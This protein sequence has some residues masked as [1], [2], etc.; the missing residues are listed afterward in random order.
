MNLSSPYRGKTAILTAI[1]VFLPLLPLAAEVTGTVKLVGK[2]N[3]QDSTFYAK[4]NGCGESPVRKTE[5]WKIGPHGELQDVVVW[6]VNPKMNGI[7]TVTPAQ[8]PQIKQQGC[9]YEPHVIAALAGEPINFINA[10]PTLHNIHAKVCN[11]PSQPPA[12]DVFNFGESVQGQQIAQ[13]FDTP[14][15]YLISCDVHPWM[16]AWARIL[17]KEVDGCFA[18]TGPDGKFQFPW[19]GHLADGDY[20][21]QAWHSRFLDLL[22]ATLHVKN[23]NGT[24]NFQFDGTKSF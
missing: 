1:S 5:N 3:S 10:D 16:Q 15:L 11:D 19:G 22:T 24:V 21:V 17:P 12:D 9:R 18:V 8:S 14:G 20:Q 2:P 6:I 7:P 23:G 4:A 13:S